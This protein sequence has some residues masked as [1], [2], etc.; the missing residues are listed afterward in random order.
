L[1]VTIVTK[2]PPYD[3]GQPRNPPSSLA[4]QPHRH[5]GTVVADPYPRFIAESPVKVSNLSE[6]Q[7]SASPLTGVALPDC[8]A[9]PH[10]ALLAEGRCVPGDVCLQV[11]NG[12]QIDRFLRRNP[13]FAQGCLADR[14]WE[15]R[16][17]AA[18]Y[19]SLEVL[20]QMPRDADEVVRRVMV[21]RLPIDEL[22]EYLRDPDREVRMTV[23]NR[24]APE[25]LITLLE[26]DD[27]LV[28]L[29]VAKRLPH[30]QLRRMAED[31]DREVRKAVARR[32]PPFALSL[33][34]KDEDE[35]VRR[36]VASRMLPDDA[37]TMLPDGDWLVRLEAAQRAPLE[38]IAELVD[39]VEP[40]VRE[41]VRQ[42][43]SDYLLG[44]D[45]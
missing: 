24:L 32:L 39:D 15:R 28:R 37:A 14:F 20:R 11:Q 36:I 18:R 2:L 19:A 42:R 12:R 38:S 31:E 43:L 35:E 26:D 23:A 7:S 45:K 6:R 5:I 44:E 4:L 8:T 40:D 13:Q 34:R 9:C 41:A 3:F 16:A 29:Q 21:S 30:G 1:D 25:R 33:L 27:Y 10:R 17:I 22:D